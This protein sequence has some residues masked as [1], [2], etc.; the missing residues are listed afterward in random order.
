MRPVTVFFDLDGVV[1]DFV[2]AALAV[3]AAALPVEDV[4]WDFPTQIGFESVDDA[5]FWAPLG[6]DFWAGLALYPDGLCLLKAAESLVGPDCIALLT[7]PCDTPGCVQG[8]LAWVAKHLPDYRKRLF[9]GGEKEL[10]A[11]PA[12][13]LVDDNDTNVERFTRAG[14]Y[15][16]KP[17]RPWNNRKPACLRGGAFD[18]PKTFEELKTVVKYAGS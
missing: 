3:H 18:V 14:G 5:K 15:A 6:F 7:S 16:V 17:A 10:F 1:A 9:V 11:G 4:T 13:V 12:K 2:S 8:K